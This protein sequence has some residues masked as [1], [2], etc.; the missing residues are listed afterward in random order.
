MITTFAP[1]QL[2]FAPRPIPAELFSSWLLRVAAANYISLRE[3]VDGLESM[4]PGIPVNQS[5]DL[6]L[7]PSFLRALSRFC[8]VPLEKLQAMDLV[9]RTPQL[10]SALLLQ[11]SNSGWLCERRKA[12]RLG[13]AYCPRCI[14]S[15]RVL[16]V[17][18]EWCFAC[19]TRCRVHRTWL[20]VGCPDCGESDPI[21]FHLSR[22]ERDVGCWSCG[23]N[24]SRPT[25][26]TNARPDSEI[27]HVVEDAYR[28]ALVG[29]APH[30]SLLGKVTHHAFRRFVDDMLQL[31]ASCL[32]PRLF[33]GATSGEED[34]WHL[35]RQDL[36]D[37]I[38]ELISNATPTS[39]VRRRRS[40]Q[41]RGLKLWAALLLLVPNSEGECLL[42]VST[43]WPAPVQRQLAS[44]LLQQRRRRW[45]HSPFQGRALR[46]RFKCHD[47]FVI[48]DLRAGK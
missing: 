4:Y 43:L 39:D 46:S 2:P 1:A 13:Y 36:F 10:Q 23:C 14:A 42:K 15:E 44:A 47:P 9:Q 11:F 40:R 33:L 16:H 25:N 29:V 7:S 22:C 3:L 30:P 6:C 27:I 19:I 28:A 31:L 5:L 41:T 18:W 35:S 34:R 26:P 17:P 45:P 8:R 48:R 32:N 37:V 21:S 24:L 20:Q 12:Q 38:G